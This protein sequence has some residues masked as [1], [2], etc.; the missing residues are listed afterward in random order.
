MLSLTAN[1]QALAPG[2]SRDRREGCR[3]PKQ[4]RKQRK[5]AGSDKEK[6]GYRPVF[7]VR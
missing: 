7:P 4:R 5:K 3:S 1:R 2:G 6:A